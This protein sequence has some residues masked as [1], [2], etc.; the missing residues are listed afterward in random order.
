MTTPHNPVILRVVHQCNKPYSPTSFH[1]Y[2]GKKTNF[3][4][5]WKLD[6]VTSLNNFIS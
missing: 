6:H 4:K 3:Y 2:R 5:D 1:E